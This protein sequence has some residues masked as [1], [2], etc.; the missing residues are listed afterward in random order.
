MTP[1]A[2]TTEVPNVNGPKEKS[3]LI[4]VISIEVAKLKFTHD[5]T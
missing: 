1:V 3:V 2:K 4:E 5:F